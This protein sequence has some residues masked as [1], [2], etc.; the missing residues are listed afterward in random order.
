M[1]AYNLNTHF[2][3]YLLR[4]NHFNPNG[5]IGFMALQ[6]LDAFGAFGNGD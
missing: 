6:V 4:E 1:S 3:A 2:G 5:I